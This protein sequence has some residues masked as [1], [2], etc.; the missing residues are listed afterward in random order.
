M[1]EFL[2]VFGS[3]LVLLGIV[4]VILALTGRGEQGWGKWPTV[5][6]QVLESGAFRK[7]RHLPG[8]TVV[9]YTPVVRYA[10]EVRG[11]MYTSKKRNFLPPYRS[12]YN[13]PQK[14]QEITERYP[15]GSTVTVHYNPH[16]PAQAVLEVERSVGYNA[17]FVSGL[18]NAGLG[19]LIILLYVLLDNI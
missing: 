5:T 19:V 1:M 4:Y 9:T 6:G 2:L 18:V 13:D 16:G 11:R 7:V 8:G 14:A 3:G 17:E 15:V 12:T 10:Y